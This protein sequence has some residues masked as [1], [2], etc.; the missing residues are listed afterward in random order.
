MDRLNLF[1]WSRDC[2]SRYGHASSRAPLILEA[3]SACDKHGGLQDV[4]LER[5]SSGCVFGSVFERLPVDSKALTV[6]EYRERVSDCLVAEGQHCMR[7]RATCRAPAA[8]ICI[9]GT[10]C[11]P[12]SRANRGSQV[13]VQHPDMKQFY[14]WA[15]IMHRDQPAL[16][17]HENVVGFDDRILASALGELYEIE[18][19]LDVSPSHAGFGFLRRARKYHLLT[20]KSSRVSLSPVCQV[21]QSIVQRVAKNVDNWPGLVWRATPR[22]L[23][24]ELAA[25]RS[26]RKSRQLTDALEARLVADDALVASSGSAD[27]AEKWRSLLTPDQAKYL[28]TYI[29]LWRQ[30]HQQG[31]EATPSC[32]FDLGDSPGY[33]GL[34]A[35]RQLPTLRHRQSIWWSPLHGRW[36]THREKA[37]CMGFP[38]YEDLANRARVGLDVSTGKCPQALG[39]AM[40]VASVGTVLLATM[41]SAE[42]P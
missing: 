18:C 2:R 11:R 10:S 22:E 16:I 32:I 7:H 3:V 13:G 20:L 4:L 33:K 28:D 15:R 26:R 21:Y 29:T 14:A 39:N 25:A 8:L 34:P 9:A 17:I 5:S 27:A 40:H 30:R 41:F 42:W 19:C 36:M 6:E 24:E 1:Q 12:W 38:V 23:E 31:P 37:G 35:M